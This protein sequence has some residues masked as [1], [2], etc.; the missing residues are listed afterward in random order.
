MCLLGILIIPRKVV[1]R[2]MTYATGIGKA[3]RMQNRTGHFSRISRGMALGTSYSGI[4]GNV[5][6]GHAACRIQP[7]R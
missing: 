1:W 7:S 6:A 4:V 3:K 5:I 2:D